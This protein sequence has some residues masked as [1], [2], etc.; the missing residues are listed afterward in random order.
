MEVMNAGSPEA[1]SSESRH[2]LIAA[3][4]ITFAMLLRIEYAKFTVQVFALSASFAQEGR[5]S[6]QSQKFL[7]ALGTQLVQSLARCC[8]QSVC[9][10]PGFRY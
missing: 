4:P 5:G 10:V 8:G 1:V 6:I 3:S 9:A 7:C 2:L